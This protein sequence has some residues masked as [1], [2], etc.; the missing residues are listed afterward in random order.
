M[1]LGIEIAWVAISIPM[2]RAAMIRFAVTGRYRSFLHIPANALFLL[3][4]MG[5]FISLAMFSLMTAVLMIAGSA[6]I[7]LTVV[8]A[9]LLPL[10]TL[11]IYYWSTAYEFG[12]LAYKLRKRTCPDAF[13]PARIMAELADGP[14]LTSVAARAV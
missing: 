1:R 12:E 10:I 14:P 7:S 3:R 13:P 5:G 2:H 8:G 4:N 9:A 11:P 6:L